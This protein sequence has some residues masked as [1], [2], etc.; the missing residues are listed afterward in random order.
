[1]IGVTSKGIFCADIIQMLN[2]E[3]AEETELMEASEIIDAAVKALESESYPKDMA[4]SKQLSIRDMDFSYC[5]IDSCKYVPVWRFEVKAEDTG[6]TA[7]LQI[8]A[9]TGEFIDFVP[10]YSY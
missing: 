3:T 1:M 10:T 9:V 6:L 8:N 7:E 5:L 2:V 4:E